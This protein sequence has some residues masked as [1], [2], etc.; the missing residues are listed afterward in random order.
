VFIERDG[1]K[2]AV[3]SAIADKEMMMILDCATL[4]IKSINDV[5]R[6]TRISHS[7]I[8]RKIKWMMGSNL[9][10]TEKIAITPAGKK[11]TLSKVR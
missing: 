10:F 8:Y 7:T 11:F 9:L 4:R 3:L 1:F 2:K 6:E 5:I